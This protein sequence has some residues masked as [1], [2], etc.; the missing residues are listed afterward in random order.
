M[1]SKIKFFITGSV[2]PDWNNSSPELMSILLC[3]SRTYTS[4]VCSFSYVLQNI[5]VS[6]LVHQGQMRRK[7]FSRKLMFTNSTKNTGVTYT[8]GHSGGSSFHNSL[9]C[10]LLCLFENTVYSD[11]RLDSVV[12]YA[13]CST[14]RW[15]VKIESLEDIIHF[16][17]LI[18]VMKIQSNRR[19]YEFVRSTN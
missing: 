10:E 12:C 1:W 16:H 14:P 9:F 5:L 4:G 7:S 2:Q 17:D 18:L 13:I 15:H 3:E 8:A 11:R 6:D 19:L